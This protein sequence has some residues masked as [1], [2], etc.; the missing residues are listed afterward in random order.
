MIGSYKELISRQPSYKKNILTE[1][2][3]IPSPQSNTAEGYLWKL[4]KCIYGLSDAS[5]KWYLRVKNSVNSNS[6]TISK[7]DPSLFLWYNE[8]DE[9]IG[10]ILG[11][12][13][14]FL[15]A[16]NKDFHKTIITKFNYL[17]L[18][19]TTNSTI[20]LYQYQYIQN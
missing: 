16:G 3:V 6:G 10:Y 1:V 8:S 13:D 12:V 11:H 18:N 14:D 9:L 17:G 19:V 20:T 2:F 7:V 5:L 15:F 4:N